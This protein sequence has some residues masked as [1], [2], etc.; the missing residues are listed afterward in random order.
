MQALTAILSVYA[1]IG[2]V[3]AIGWIADKLNGRSRHKDS[4]SY[5]SCA[6]E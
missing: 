2:S 1:F 6:M 3:C 5:F 4:A